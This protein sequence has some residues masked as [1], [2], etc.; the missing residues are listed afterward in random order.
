P[1]R[2]IK[3]HLLFF[4]NNIFIHYGSQVH[5]DKPV[6]SCGFAGRPAKRE[7]IY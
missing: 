1:S 4:L 2:K 3:H 6:E 5:A 7:A